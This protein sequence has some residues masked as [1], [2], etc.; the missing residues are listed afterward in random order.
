MY[1]VDAVFFQKIEDDRKGT[2]IWHLVLE[3]V[4]NFTASRDRVNRFVL[5]CR[6]VDG[7]SE[8]SQTNTIGDG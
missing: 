8:H 1:A 2:C 4:E 7:M 3:V 6:V 5:A